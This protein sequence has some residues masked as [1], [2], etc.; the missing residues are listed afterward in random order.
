MNLVKNL[1][2]RYCTCTARRPHAV[3]NVKTRGL[4]SSSERVQRKLNLLVFFT[5]NQ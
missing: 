3:E 2:E 5:L 1:V 4:A